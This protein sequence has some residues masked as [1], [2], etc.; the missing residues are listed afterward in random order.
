MP[1]LL[2]PPK[3]AS[4]F[5]RESLPPVGSM[6]EILQGSQSTVGFYAPKASN[7]T[8]N[9]PE[10][11]RGVLFDRPPA[12]FAA[13]AERMTGT[14]IA[15]QDPKAV[16]MMRRSYLRHELTHAMRER[17][18][19]ME[20]VGQPGL[21]NVLKTIREEAIANFE[22]IRGLERMKAPQTAPALY[23]NAV[24][25]V[26]PTMVGSVA[27]SYARQGGVGRAAF[28]GTLKPLLGIA[29]RL[30]LAKRADHAG[31][32][33]AERLGDVPPEVLQHAR[34]LAPRI[35]SGPEE[36]MHL[37]LF[38]DGA[39]V[40]FAAY[41]RVGKAKK[42]VLATILG[43]NMTPRNSTLLNE[44][45]LKEHL[46]SKEKTAFIGVGMPLNKETYINDPSEWGP[47]FTIGLGG[48]SINL[49]HKPSSLGVGLGF[50]GPFPNYR[51][52]DKQSEAWRK[53]HRKREKESEGEKSAANRM[54]KIMDQAK[55]L[56][57]QAGMNTLTP[58]QNRLLG[59]AEAIMSHPKLQGYVWEPGMGEA[60]LNRPKS[61]FD[62]Y[63]S[64][65]PA[66]EGD[67]H[68]LLEEARNPTTPP[69]R[70]AELTRN[71][72][73]PLVE[74]AAL[75]PNAGEGMAA[76]HTMRPDLREANP[77]TALAR[78]GLGA[79]IPDVPLAQ[80][81]KE[82]PSYKGPGGHLNSQRTKLRLGGAND[83]V[84]R[85]WVG[86]AP[87]NLR[88]YPLSGNSV[89]Y[90][91]GLSPVTQAYK[92]NPRLMGLDKLAAPKTRIFAGLRV[93]IDRP[94]GFV[95]HGKSS[96]GT[97]WE[98]EYKCDYGYLAGT[99]GGD[100]D[101]LDVFL[102]PEEKGDA[103]LI[104]Q[105]KEDGS[106]DEYKL[107]L[108]FKDA[109][110]AKAMY[111]THIPA[112]FLGK[113][114][115]MPIGVIQG[116][117]GRPV[118]HNKTAAAGDGAEAPISV[119][120][121]TMDAARERLRKNL[122]GQG[123]AP[124]MGEDLRFKTPEFAG[125]PLARQERA[126]RARKD[127]KAYLQAMQEGPGGHIPLS[128][129]PEQLEALR[130]SGGV[131][132]LRDLA[133]GVMGAGFKEL[134][135]SLLPEDYAKT[136]ADASP[137]SLRVLKGEELQ[138]AAK[139]L[140]E[141]GPDHPGRNAAA[142]KL[143]AADRRLLDKTVGTH[144]KGLL[145]G[146]ARAILTTP[147]GMAFG[148]AAAGLVTSNMWMPHALRAGLS[149]SLLSEEERALPNEEKD[150]LLAERSPFYHQFLQRND[151]TSDI[152]AKEVLK[153]LDTALVAAQLRAI[154][155]TANQGRLR[156]FLDPKASL[157]KLVGAKRFWHGTTVG[158]GRKILETGI[159]PG[160]GGHVTG[161]TNKAT[162][163]QGLADELRAYIAAG[164]STEELPQELQ[165]QI[166][167]MEAHLGAPVPHD[168]QRVTIEKG[169]DGKI[170]RDEKMRPPLPDQHIQA[171]QPAI[172]MQGST[173]LGEGVTHAD[174]DA[175]GFLDNAR[176]NMFLTTDPH[177]AKAY[178]LAQNPELRAANM[179]QGLNHV[180]EVGEL[181]KD[182]PEGLITTSKGRKALW[183]A[184]KNLYS[185]AQG[186]A[187]P[188][189]ENPFVLGGAMPEEEWKRLM[190]QDGD[191]VMQ[192]GAYRLKDEHRVT[193][194]GPGG[195][196]A[197]AAPHG[198]TIP[199]DQISVGDASL[200]QILKARSKNLGDYIR[201]KGLP[202]GERLLGL[203]KR[204]LG[205]VGQAGVQAGV[206]GLALHNAFGPLAKKLYRKYQERNL[207]QQEGVPPV[208]ATPIPE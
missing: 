202:E 56:M 205:G 149:R 24:K 43:P 8:L 17:A 140:Q 123:V 161:F 1:S 119:G 61:L 48:P 197:T 59:E 189:K 183:G 100:G 137:E 108:G 167:G 111:L 87:T 208:E 153:P 70:L 196:D 116:L 12:D 184:A 55:R 169:P 29:E 25:A 73:A 53:K 115:R 114:E 165:K 117:T 204:F 206:A 171:L 188:T 66:P 144:A 156:G 2:H 11:K 68:K 80:I 90:S 190:V 155:S 178:A 7:P 96:D 49:R 145:R 160:F 191:N 99:Q 52:A 163:R 134:H 93:R 28:S 74:A 51:A 35:G 81:R 36:R 60:L 57:P 82:I 78:L 62:R 207:P 129:T 166:L 91:Q 85:R 109:R 138:E 30:G 22:G 187:D 95:Q 46:M 26:V 103:F 158:A 14:P 37:P 18:G 133:P 54:A 146:G 127:L 97:P 67:L 75:N 77:S 122:A 72:H 113:I 45:A 172:P 131:Q 141:M 65:H 121:A 102:G 9:V 104:H 192:T 105:R 86:G 180:K 38:H 84:A 15:Q 64:S 4:F 50:L 63:V 170:H 177:G 203:N 31:D 32:R 136:L 41:K 201:G 16:E 168:Y 58:S 79:P 98:R 110:V 19:H 162:H 107:M 159:D 126:H 135:K 139:A 125:D 118:D 194:Y 5:A 176:G 23:Q 40:G 175:R 174:I 157:E 101:G 112:K 20:G 150:K 193:P 83:E 186:G 173:S 185:E 200:K 89:H 195:P 120:P 27:G 44:S 130:V 69:S 148:G 142:A 21:R 147:K 154:D 34:D 13:M 106:F 47:D 42:P 71:N 39:P 6:G 181:L 199:A 76:I 179:E 88:L 182:G 92:A 124:E 10:G 164:G 3:L 143:M 152:T 132:R 94:K 33:F 128:L 151:E 198:R